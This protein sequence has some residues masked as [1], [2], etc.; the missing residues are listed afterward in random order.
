[1]I[2]IVHFIFVWIQVTGNSVLDVCDFKASVTNRPKENRNSLL[3][4][5]ERRFKAVHS[6][7]QVEASGGQLAITL[8]LNPS[9]RSKNG[10]AWMTGCD[11]ET[12]NSSPVVEARRLEPQSVEGC[13]HAEQAGIYP[14]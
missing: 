11:Y 10:S 13:F 2:R 8:T 14:K 7:S 6:F 1:M 3:R 12:A 9:I 5:A 4:F